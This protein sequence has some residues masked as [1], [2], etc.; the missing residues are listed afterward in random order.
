MKTINRQSIQ[1][2]VNDLV[3]DVVG[4]A[5]GVRFAAA[6]ITVWQVLPGGWRRV[7]LMHWRRRRR[8][9]PRAERPTITLQSRSLDAHGRG[10]R[11]GEVTIDQV[12][13]HGDRLAFF[14]PVLDHVP[15][16]FV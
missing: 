16:A 10:N 13:C 5:N 14:A 9:R 3:L 8:T 7:L 4:D 6:F 11:R 2:G 12:D 15:L 1:L